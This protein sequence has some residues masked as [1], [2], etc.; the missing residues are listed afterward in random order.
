MKNLKCLLPIALLLL[1]FFAHA[2]S[3]E[4][5]NFIGRWLTED[6]SQ[7]IEIY[8]E[9]NMFYGKIIKAAPKSKKAE[10]G[11]GQLVLIAMKLKGKNLEGGTV[12]DIDTGKEYDAK[13]FAVDA[14][15][16]KLKVTA[17]LVSFSEV[18]TREF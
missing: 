6:K 2:Q 4:E 18:W 5:K 8:K 9:N 13:L 17:M 15:K 16:I 1:N 10:S 7:T 11:I 3:K 12:K 14:N